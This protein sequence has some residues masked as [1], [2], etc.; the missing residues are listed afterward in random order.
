MGGGSKHN[1]GEK[2]KLKK[3]GVAPEMYKFY[4]WGLR[5]ADRHIA[6]LNPEMLKL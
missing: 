4:T 1:N 3:L 2:I 5:R 6:E